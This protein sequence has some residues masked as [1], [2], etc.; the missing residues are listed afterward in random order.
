MTTSEPVVHELFPGTCE[1]DRDDFV[2]I[3]A[4]R[5]HI[6]RTPLHENDPTS[7]PINILKPGHEYRITLKP[8]TITCWAGGIDDL[9]ARRESNPKS[10]EQY[11]ITMFKYPDSMMVTLAC[12]DQLI[13]VVE[14]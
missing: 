9:L 13:L 2:E 3:H 11:G 5:P 4:S 6:T 1:P 14:A 8:Q 10:E 12:D 7:D